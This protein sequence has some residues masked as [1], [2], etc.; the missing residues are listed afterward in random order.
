MAVMLVDGVPKWVAS[1]EEGGLEPMFAT[2]RTMVA[3][4][5]NVSEVE[6]GSEL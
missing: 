2:C 4:V 5:T 6:S 3:A 1:V